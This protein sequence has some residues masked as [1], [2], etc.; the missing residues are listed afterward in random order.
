MQMSVRTELHKIIDE[1]SDDTVS[2]IYEWLNFHS[3]KTTRY[4][5][6]EIKEFYSLL[7]QYEKGLTKSYTVEETFAIARGQMKLDDL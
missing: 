5:P 6:E 2:D 4:S 1:A 7:D 3:P